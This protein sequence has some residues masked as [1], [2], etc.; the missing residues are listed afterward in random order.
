[1]SGSRK[2]ITFSGKKSAPNSTP[3]SPDAQKPANLKLT[4]S[5]LTQEKR[6]I[7]MTIFFCKL[8]NDTTI[9]HDFAAQ[10]THPAPDA[11][12]KTSNK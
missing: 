7:L 5:E 11:D 10:S 1:M 4:F 8:D 2:L 3:I 6:T 9:K 12:E